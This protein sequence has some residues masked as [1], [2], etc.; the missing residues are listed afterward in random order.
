MN[1]VSRCPI[2]L[3]VQFQISPIFL[4]DFTAS[5]DLAT[6]RTDVAILLHS[7][8]HFVVVKSFWSLFLAHGGWWGCYRSINPDRPLNMRVLYSDHVVYYTPESDS[9][10]TLMMTYLECTVSL[11]P[12]LFSQ[13]PSVG[14]TTESSGRIPLAA[15]GHLWL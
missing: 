9:P 10:Q 12:N 8:R 11:R 15:L 14:V 2:D 13:F 1:S 5:L 3:F 4:K 6:A 7:S